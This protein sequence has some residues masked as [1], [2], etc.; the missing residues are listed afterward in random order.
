MVI[1]KRREAF[2]IHKMLRLLS[3]YAFN[4]TYESNKPDIK[5]MKKTHTCKTQTLWKQHTKT[6]E[7]QNQTQQNNDEYTK[8]N[9]II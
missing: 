7:Q 5:T 4:Q 3:A 2:F 6:Q 1:F 9:T 8:G